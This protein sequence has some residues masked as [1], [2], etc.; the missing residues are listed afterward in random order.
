MNS[1]CPSH[2]L[3]TN[4][5]SPAGTNYL[6]SR[7]IF[8]YWSLCKITDVVS[9]KWRILPG[10]LSKEFTTVSKMTQVEQIVRHVSLLGQDSVVL[11]MIRTI[12]KKTTQ[13]ITLLM[14]WS[15]H[16]HKTT[17][18]VLFYSVA[19]HFCWNAFTTYCPRLEADSM[20]TSRSLTYDIAYR[21]IYCNDASLAL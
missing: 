14:A 16:A 13:F 10:L 15:S 6:Y 17:N 18:I 21:W 11:Y 12:V 3:L 5:A 4:P 9:T 8:N 19:Q 2:S 20:Q 7:C 1:L